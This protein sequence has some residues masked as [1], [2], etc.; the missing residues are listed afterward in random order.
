MERSTSRLIFDNYRVKIE[1]NICTDFFRTFDETQ[2]HERKI[3]R[4]RAF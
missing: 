4:I 1:F 3:Q 2:N